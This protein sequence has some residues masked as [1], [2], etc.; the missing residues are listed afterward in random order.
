MSG[1]GAGA[2]ALG[3]LRLRRPAAG[4]TLTKGGRPRRHGAR[5]ACADPA[6][7]PA[8]TTSLVGQD[9]QDGGVTVRAWAGLHIPHTSAIPATA[10]AGRGRSGA[11]L[12]SGFSPAGPRPDPPTQGAVAVVAGPGPLD[13][14]LAWRADS[15]ASTWTTPSG[16]PSRPSAGPGHPAQADRWTRLVL[17]A[18]T[19][20][21]LARPVAVDARPTSSET[22]HPGPQGPPDKPSP[23]STPPTT[24]DGQS[25]IP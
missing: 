14:E 23:S 2:A 20:L 7:W 1:G 19:Q 25:S 5:F 21:R 4:G 22:G 6:T 10:P 18:T 3:P 24:F 9:D 16:S 12:W 17:A 13:L 8:P 11:A 15:A